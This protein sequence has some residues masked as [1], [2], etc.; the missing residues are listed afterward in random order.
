MTKIKD[1]KTTVYQWKGKTVPAPKNG[2]IN[3]EDD[4]PGLGLTISDKYLDSCDI[5]N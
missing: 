5:I 4:K 2:F 3:L 1:I